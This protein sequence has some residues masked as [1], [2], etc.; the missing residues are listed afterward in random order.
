MRDTSA[1]IRKTCKQG[2][3]APKKEKENGE[4][5]CY[6]MSIQLWVPSGGE[7]ACGGVEK[8]IALYAGGGASYVEPYGTEP[9]SS[10]SRT[11]RRCA[12]VVLRIQLITSSGSFSCR[13]RL[14]PAPSFCVA[15]DGPGWTGD[16]RLSGDW[17]TTSC[18]SE[19]AWC[20]VDEDRETDAGVG[21]KLR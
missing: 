19:C 5:S 16:G 7:R 3:P 8:S 21:G 13:T 17:E 2:D 10:S 18:D 6:S 11:R 20:C 15:M 12:R 1:A 4:I 9:W 14:P